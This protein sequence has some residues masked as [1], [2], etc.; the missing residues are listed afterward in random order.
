MGWVLK[1][2]VLIYAIRGDFKTSK[3]QKYF[4]DSEVL[5]F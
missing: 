5:K 1:K 4:Y 3:S 2:Y